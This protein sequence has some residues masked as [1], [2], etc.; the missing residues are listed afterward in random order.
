M[1][2]LDT[3]HLVVLQRRTPPGRSI[4]RSV[5]KPGGLSPSPR[6]DCR[7]LDGAMMGTTSAMEWVAVGG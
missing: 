7:G 6:L 4:H 1:F 5:E 3:D 2:L